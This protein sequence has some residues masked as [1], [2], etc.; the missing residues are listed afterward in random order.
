[1]TA[2]G[3][4]IFT[5]CQLAR[6]ARNLT[7]LTPGIAI[8]KHDCRLFTLRHNVR[9]PSVQRFPT[10]DRTQLCSVSP[11]FAIYHH[12]HHHHLSLLYSSSAGSRNSTVSMT[13]HYLSTA[14]T[15][16]FCYTAML[17]ITAFCIRIYRAGRTVSSYRLSCNMFGTM[18]AVDR[19]EI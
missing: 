10:S 12:H 15:K 6:P 16:T 13:K 18:P 4:G 3:V 11:C 17:I 1:M 2:D 7:L 19:Q 14:L 8:H 5:C 9:A